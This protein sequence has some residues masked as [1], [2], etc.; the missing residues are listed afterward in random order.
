MKK[1]PSSV[2]K[3][4]KDNLNDI[5]ETRGYRANSAGKIDEYLFAVTSETEAAHEFHDIVEAE[6][7]NAAIEWMNTAEKD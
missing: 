6:G 5:Q 3:L 7:V 4:V 2:L 1:T